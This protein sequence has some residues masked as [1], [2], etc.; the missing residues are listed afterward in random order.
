MAKSAYSRE[1]VDQFLSHIE[2]PASQHHAQPTLALLQALHVHMIS[3]VPYD[4]LSLHYNPAHA[5]SIDPQH[6]FRKIVA[7]G[8][9]RGGYCMEIAVLYNHMLVALGYDAYLAGVRTRPRVHGVPEGD[10]PGW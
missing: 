10:F 3:T 5:I 4:N 8:R 1:Q 6:V 2:L 9:G 7:S